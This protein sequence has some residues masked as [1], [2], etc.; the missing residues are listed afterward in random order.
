[1]TS[2]NKSQI[3]ELLN[4]PV[5]VDQA[6]RLLGANQ[7]ADELRSKSTHHHNDIGHNC[8]QRYVC[9][10]DV[11]PGMLD[12][13]REESSFGLSQKEHVVIS[14]SST[15]CASKLG[16]SSLKASKGN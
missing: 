8:N 9:G 7:T 14:E 15:I 4:N 6:I 12:T 3:Q 2:H 5:Y 1:M 16:T 13:L 10:L 11:G